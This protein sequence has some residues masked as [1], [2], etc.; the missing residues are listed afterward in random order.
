MTINEDGMQG[1]IYSKFGMRI[2]Y[3]G[4]IKT[5]ADLYREVIGD[6]AYFGM[7]NYRVDIAD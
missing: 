4:V 7:L 6:R 5:K 1:R 2:V 3:K